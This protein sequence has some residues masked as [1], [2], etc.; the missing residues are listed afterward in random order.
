MNVQPTAYHCF[1]R[2]PLFGL[3]PP[4]SNAS[5]GLIALFRKESSPDARMRASISRLS[6][7]RGTG[8]GEVGVGIDNTNAVI[9]RGGKFVEVREGTGMVNGG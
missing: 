8:T 6:T 7:I 5:F 1:T 2:K 9:A 3:K 4:L